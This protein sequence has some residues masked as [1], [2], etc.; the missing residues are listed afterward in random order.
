MK[1][2]VD[3]ARGGTHIGKSIDA[4]KTLLED[5]ASNNYHWSSERVTPKKGNGRYGRC[6]HTSNQLGGCTCTKAWLDWVLRLFQV[7]R[8]VQLEYMLFVRHVVYKGTHLLSNSMVPLAL[9]M[10]TPCIVFTPQHKAI[11]TPTPTMKD[12]WAT[13]FLCTRTLPLKTRALYS[14]L[15]SSIDVTPRTFNSWINYSGWWFYYY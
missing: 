1:I 3:V 14:C 11:L 6:C 15:G 5:M 12:R 8:R 10:L 2:L 4:T 7:I 9:R 13:L